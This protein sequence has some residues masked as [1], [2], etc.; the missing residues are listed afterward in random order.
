VSISLAALR[1]TSN[2]HTSSSFNCIS[3]FC[4]TFDFVVLKFKISLVLKVQK[5]IEFIVPT[6]ALI[7]CFF[8]WVKGPA[9]DATD[10][11]QL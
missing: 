7:M 8:L 1:I 3:V 2:I 11:P 4:F 10:A 6:K 5:G 9:A